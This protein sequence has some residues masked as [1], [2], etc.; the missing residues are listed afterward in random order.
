MKPMV[1]TVD[2]MRHGEPVGGS[3]YRGQVDDPL[4]DKGWAQM[5][6]AVADHCPWQ[7]VVSS[8]LRRCAA[9]AAELA[10]RHALPLSLEER[11]KEI[12]FGVWEGRTKAE[13]TAQNPDALERFYA[14]PVRHRPPRAEPLSEFQQRIVAAWWD[15]LQAHAGGQVLLVAHAGVIRML[16]SHVLAAPPERMFRIQVP[17]A[18]ISRIRVDGEGREAAAHLLFHAGCL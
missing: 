6:A 15:L 12:G 5:R 9:F 4:S 18:A 14:D 13:I 1:T 3:K 17:N 16:L 10:Q 7:A 11:F 2:L 8:P